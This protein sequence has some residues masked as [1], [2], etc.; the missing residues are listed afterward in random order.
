MLGLHLFCASLSEVYPEVSEK[1]KGFGTL[2]N[3]LTSKLMPTTSMLYA[4][5]ASKS[6]LGRFSLRKEGPVLEPLMALLATRGE[7]GE[8]M[9]GVG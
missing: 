3:F 4:I 7:R 6:L 1:L 5:S 9:K 2:K 8:G